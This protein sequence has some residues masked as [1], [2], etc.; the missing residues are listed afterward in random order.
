MD[1]ISSNDSSPAVT[2][3]LNVTLPPLQVSMRARSRVNFGVPHLLSS[4]SFSRATKALE[5]EHHGEPLGAFWDDVLAQATASIFTAVA[6]LE[7]YANELFADR[8]WMFPAIRPDLLKALWDVYE[9][10]T[11][12]EKFDL[13]LMLQQLPLLDRKAK[14]FQD[15]DLLIRLRNALVHF[16]PEWDDEREKHQHLSSELARRFPASPFIPAAPLFPM[17]WASHACTAWAVSSVLNFIQEFE[18]AAKLPGRIDK[19]IA[20]IGDH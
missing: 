1:P 10:K 20:R 14:F 17:G 4:A 11:L 5:I 6:G 18:K 15:A 7:S 19:F 12:L 9:R 3:T 8:Q 13:A 16:K 2:A